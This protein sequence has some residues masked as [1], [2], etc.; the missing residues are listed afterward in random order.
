MS[1]EKIETALKGYKQVFPEGLDR[2]NT[3]CDRV[4]LNGDSLESMAKKIDGFKDRKDATTQ[5]GYAWFWGLYFETKKSKIAV[6]FPWHENRSKKDGIQL[7]RS[8]AV[9]T[10]GKVTPQKVDEIF[11]KFQYEFECLSVAE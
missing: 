10:R 3:L 11:K 5:D 1:N 6:L 9:Y 7:D 2:L 4:L 8:I